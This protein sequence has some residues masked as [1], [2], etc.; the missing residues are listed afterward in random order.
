MSG[1]PYGRGKAPERACLKVEFWPEEDARLWTIACARGDILDDEIGSRADYSAISNDKDRKGYGRWLNHLGFHDRQA[2]RLAPADRITP[3]RVKAYVARLEEL[4]ASSQTLLARL[5]ELGAVA[6][7]MGPDRDWSFI[8]KLAS[9]IRARHRPARDKE[10]RHLTNELVDLGLRLMASADPNGGVEAAVHYRDG[11]VIALLALVPL[12]RRNLAGLHL[13]QGL[14]PVGDRFLVTFT[15]DETKAGT[16][17]ELF[18]PDVLL[19]PLKVWLEVW[20]PL[21]AERTG[22][23]HKPAGDALWLS[24]HGSPMTQM[25]LYDRIRLQTAA[26]FGEPINPHHF[27]HT[28]ATTQAI[29]D[30]AHVRITAPLLSHRTLNTTER[31]YQQ[32]TAYEA[33]RAF[34]EVLNTLRSSPDAD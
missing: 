21:L 27:R 20:R 1:G 4:G 12:R 28:A 31:Y 7:V 16:P 22:R 13:G 30:P 8:N 19:E 25:A 26:A 32:A 14:L 6:K 11:L 18:L 15:E 24:S 9:R 5:Q 23:W 34:I 10:V 29:A 3:D 2:L 33:H 17:I